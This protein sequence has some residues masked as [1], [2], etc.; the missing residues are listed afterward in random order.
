[1][2]ELF[3]STELFKASPTLIIAIGSPVGPVGPPPGGQPNQDVI[4]LAL[5]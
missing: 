1:M 3:K 2:E 5:C 4:E